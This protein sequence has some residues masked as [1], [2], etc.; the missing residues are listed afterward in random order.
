MFRNTLRIP[1]YLL[2][3]LLLAWF[4]PL[5]LFSQGRSVTSMQPSSAPQQATGAAR[6][7]SGSTHEGRTESTTY[8]GTQGIK[9]PEKTAVD[10]L[11]ETF[12]NFKRPTLITQGVLLVLFSLLPFIIMILTSFLKIVIVLS[13]LR[14][15]LGVQQA[16]PNQIINGVAFMLSLF[17]MYPTVLEMYDV[18]Q[19]AVR[20]E[21]TPDSL[22]SE[23]AST[24]LLKVAAYTREPLR[25]FLKRNSSVKHHGMFYKMAYKVLPEDHRDSLKPDDFMILVPAYITSQLKDAFEIGVLIYIPF[26]VID[27]V[28]S[29][30]LLAMG[31]MMLSPVTISMPLKLFLLVMLDGWTLLVEGL[32][33]TFK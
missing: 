9:V 10:D 16:P 25:D 23:G 7:V 20:R 21:K 24:Y 5:Q 4:S 26:F 33:S 15:A 19:E 11:N 14:S 17:V 31:M 2:A 29:N 18:S 22:F 28:T 13:L 1:F 8:T 6:A 12:D 30:I 27:L 3:L 32:V